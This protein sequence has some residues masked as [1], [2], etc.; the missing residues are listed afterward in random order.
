MS[1]KE[2]QEELQSSRKKKERLEKIVQELT[3]EADETKTKWIC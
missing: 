1:K 2:V 3:K